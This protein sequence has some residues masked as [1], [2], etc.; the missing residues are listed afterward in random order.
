MAINGINNP[1]LAPLCAELAGERLFILLL[2]ALQSACK[3]TRSN[4]GGGQRAESWSSADT[5]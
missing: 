3:H 4:S 5:R 2:S 1:T